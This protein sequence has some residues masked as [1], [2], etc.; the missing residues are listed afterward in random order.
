MEIPERL[1]KVVKKI[2]AGGDQAIDEPVFDHAHHQAAHP[3]RNHGAGHPHHDGAP[4]AQHALPHFERQP[5][6]FALKCGALH[7]RQNFAGAGCSHRIEGTSGCRQQ[8]RL[9]IP[10]MRMRFG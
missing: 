1:V 8:A 4:V 9:G 5:E 6:L 3:S 2:R 7:A 10:L